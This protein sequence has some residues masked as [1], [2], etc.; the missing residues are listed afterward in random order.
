MQNFLRVGA[1]IIASVSLFVASARRLPN[2]WSTENLAFELPEVSTVSALLP[3]FVFFFSRYIG[4]VRS[5]AIDGGVLLL[6]AA[7]LAMAPHHALAILLAVVWA[8]CLVVGNLDARN[9][10]QGV[11]LWK[12]LDML[13]LLFFLSG[14][15][16]V[17]YQIVW[18]RTLFAL[19]GSDVESVT[20]IVSVFM[21]GLGLGALLGRFLMRKRQYLL[22]QFIAIEIV[23]G[24]FG[25]FSLPFAEVLRDEF[26]QGGHVALV[27]V[28][29]LL[30]ALPT[31]LMGATLPILIAYLN[32][33]YDSIGQSTGLLY[34]SNTWGSALA[35]VLTVMV[36][37][38]LTGQQAATWLAGACNLLTALGAAIFAP[39][40]TQHSGVLSP[41]AT[42]KLGPGAIAAP[43]AVV[44]SFFIGFIVLS[45]EIVWFRL[46]S[47]VSQGSPKVFGLILGAM[48]FGI[49]LGSYQMKRRV[50]SGLSVEAWLVK[51]L[52]AAS[53]LS[54]LLIPIVGLASAMSSAH[55]A[56]LVATGLTGTIAWCTG[57]VLPGLGALAEGR[58]SERNARLMAAIYA[59]NIAG[60]ALG[61]LF[62]GYWLF[63]HLTFEACATLTA[64]ALAL[65]SLGFAPSIPRILAPAAIAFCVAALSLP[66]TLQ[67]A[68]AM[69]QFEAFHPSVFAHRADSRAGVITVVSHPR[70]DTVYGG[71]AY[72]GGVN[73]DPSDSSNGIDRAYMMAALHPNPAKVLE[74]GLS[75][76]AWAAVL[77]KHE[78]VQS[79]T[80]IEINPAYLDI[81]RH[82]DELA[83]ILDDPRIEIVIDDGRRWLR[84]NS[85]ERFDFILMN[86]TFHWRSN[87]TNLLSKEFM[88]MAKD[89]LLPGGVIYFNTTG[90]DHA[91]YTAAQ[92]FRHVVRYKNF[93]A[94]SDSPFRMSP[95]ERERNLKRFRGAEGEPY[96]LVDAG[97]EQVLRSMSATALTDIADKLREASSGLTFISDDNMYTEFKL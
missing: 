20:I 71:G 51:S 4:S 90:S 29:Y 50:D 28:S 39:R 47:L 62:M 26:S 69:I 2:G 74:I 3:V 72:D 45:Q 22:Q 94:A 67:Y 80:S 13:P 91:A 97:K 52:L 44:L 83:E 59:S 95:A 77:S 56:L 92:V 66:L 1:S 86:T 11:P 68:L 9:R 30:F 82:Y 54:A 16:A 93:V 35:A 49:G 5:R 25:I 19:F 84:R 7:G 23:I 43:A 36:L 85:K 14:F 48:L 55:F 89:Q 37:F 79:L 24:L 65:L 46:L 32:E 34:A 64:M 31:L 81:I 57:G 18:Q 53:L 42:R 61:P 87:V 17:I 6:G 70:G 27:L 96:L 10:V 73:I 40:A 63:N 75:T 88:K 21:L 38:A 41:R 33:R 58:H 8:A 12:S 78:A 15:S 76:G 60:A